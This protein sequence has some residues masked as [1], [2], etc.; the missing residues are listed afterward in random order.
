MMTVCMIAVV[1][2]LCGFEDKCQPMFSCRLKEKLTKVTLGT[3]FFETHFG[4]RMLFGSFGSVFLLK[5]KD[6]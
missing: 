6:K 2:F 4:S 5:T 3:L 1:H